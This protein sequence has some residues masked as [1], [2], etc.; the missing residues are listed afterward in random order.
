M[1]QEINSGAVNAM[2]VRPGSF[3]GLHFGNLFGFKL[4]TLA[5]SLP[6]IFIIAYIC[7][8]PLFTGRVAA[9]VG[10]GLCY[11]FLIHTINFAIASLAFFFDH[12]YSLNMTKNMLLWFFTGE[13]FP[14]DL[15]P[16]SVSKA[17]RLLP[18]S[19]GYYLPA[20]YISGRIGTAFFLQGFASLAI[21]IAVMALIARLIWAKGLRNY[22]GTGA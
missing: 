13:L 20:S 11:L 21:G 18:F 12:V 1:I 6:L 19:S 10:M 5:I 7:D 8:L 2:L 22:T 15:L 17:V 14:L 3:Y 16:S 9:A 4:L